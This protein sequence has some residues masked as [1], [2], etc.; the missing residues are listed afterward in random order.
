MIEGPAGWAEF[1]PF[2]EYDDA[3]AAFWWR[4][5]VEAATVGWPSAVR[6]RV[7]VNCIV[8][9]VDPERAAAIVRD[10]GCA[11]AK[12]KVAE[13]GQDLSADLARV[14]AVRE[15]L[16][17]TGRVRVDANGAW[18]VATAV[19][20]IASLHAEVGLEYVEQPCAAVEDLARVRAGTDVPIA[21]DESIRRVDDPDRVA[22]LDAADIAV[23]KVAPLGGVARSL[24]IAQRLGLPVVV[25]SAIDTSIGLAAG[26][27]LAAALPDL[28]YACGLG[29]G[30][31][32][33]GDVVSDPLVPVNGSLEVRRP[34]VDPDAYAPYRAD[35]AT[36]AWWLARVERV[37]EVVAA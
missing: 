2:R 16:G 15:A 18:D 6:D 32:L 23:L 28:P 21:A 5:A 26:L 25:S 33:D 1:S 9:A 30:L 34:V 8:P 27:A 35:A 36:E 22:E 29:T 3:E 13:P 12:V 37:R 4:S 31:L 14:A 10:S 20:H 24:E 19:A 17:P 11:T 7:P